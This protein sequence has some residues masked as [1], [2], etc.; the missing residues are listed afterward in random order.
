MNK[1]AD[2]EDVKELKKRVKSY[3][4]L[5]EIAD[6]MNWSYQRV[7]QR[8]GGFATLTIKDFKRIEKLVKKKHKQLVTEGFR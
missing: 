5:G 7:S 6:G 2:M 4:S 3:S 8:L 1:N